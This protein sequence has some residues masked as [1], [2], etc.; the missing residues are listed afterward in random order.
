MAELPI[1]MTFPA[2]RGSSGG[3][4]ALV[5][6]GGSPVGLGSGVDR[7]G[8]RIFQRGVRSQMQFIS[9][10]GPAVRRERGGRSFS[11]GPLPKG[12]GPRADCGTSRGERNDSPGMGRSGRVF[13]F[14]FPKKVHYLDPASVFGRSRKRR[15]RWLKRGD[16]RTLSF[17]FSKVGQIWSSMMHGEYR[18]I[19][20]LLLE[21]KGFELT[22][23]LLRGRSAEGLI[24]SQ[25]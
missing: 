17:D 11:S 1:P 19:R 12:A 8:C 7:F 5:G 21:G 4:G 13:G 15:L 10:L 6:S 23:K 16:C 9:R 18:E 22:R 25:P 3:E 14:G 24:R 2:L 20:R